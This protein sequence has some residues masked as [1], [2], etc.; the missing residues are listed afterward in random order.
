MTDGISGMRGVIGGSLSRNVQVLMQGAVDGSISAR[1]IHAVRS[2]H[3]QC[4]TAASLTQV[5]R[6]TSDA[7]VRMVWFGTKGGIHRR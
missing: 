2:R 7:G 1:Q 4:S 6:A 3:Q 5:D